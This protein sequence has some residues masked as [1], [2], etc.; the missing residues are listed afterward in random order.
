MPRPKT[1]SEL[2]QDIKARDETIEAMHKQI[3]ELQKQI[4]SGVESSAVYQQALKEASAARQ[5]AEM[6]KELYQNV[7]KP[8]K[9][10]R[11][12]VL[13]DQQKEEIQKRRDAGLPLRKIAEEFGCSLATVQR[14]L[15]L[16]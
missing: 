2:E 14:A 7:T 13:T 3:Q 11:K 10:G 5:E 15:G 12:A 8:K 9:L 4:A 6:Y 16:I 1:K